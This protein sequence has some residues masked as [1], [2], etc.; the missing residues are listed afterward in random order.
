MFTG[1][2]RDVGVVERVVTKG[3]S[4]EIEITTLLDEKFLQLGSSVACNGV[5]LTVTLAQPV[6]AGKW[7][8]CAEVGPQT[9][10]V[11]QFSS[12]KAGSRINLEPALRFGDEVGGHH[13]SGHVDVSCTVIEL[14]RTDE[15][16]FALRLSI[17]SAFRKWLIPKG[18][19]AIRGVSLTVA[20]LEFSDA[21]D[22]PGEVEIMLVPHTLIHTNLG[23]CSA[24][25]F[26]EVEFDHMIKSVSALVENLLP[27]ALDAR[28]S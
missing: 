18:S 24:Q 16:F 14:A 28:Q 25:T 17:P 11:S 21:K 15:N 12:L 22:A 19:I 23:E 13:V 6:S 27:L 10:A 9:L 2:I 1:L 26:V 8:F 7:K 5:C 4:L 20:K 3:A